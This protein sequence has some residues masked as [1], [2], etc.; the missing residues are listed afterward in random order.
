MK[1]VRLKGLTWRDPRGYGPLPA[2]ERSFA[3]LHR[4]YNLEFEW[5][6]HPLAEFES[7]PLV[8]VVEQYDLM[9]A[10]HPQIARACRGG[11]LAALGDLADEFVGPSL[12][13][14][15]WEG[16]LWA[17]PV[18]AACHVAAY[19]S[20]L[21][22]A[23]PQTWDDLERLRSAG[24]RIAVPLGGVH[25]LMALLSLLGSLLRSPSTELKEIS[26]GDLQEALERLRWLASLCP[27]ECLEIDPLQVLTGLAEGKW[28]YSPLVFGYAHYE[29]RGVRFG[30]SPASLA[31][32]SRGVLGGAGIAVSA[33]S[34]CPELAVAFAR[35]CCE[36]STQAE[37]WPTGGGQPAHRQAWDRLST[38][39]DFFRCTREAIEASI[40]RPRTE[41][42]VATQTQ[43]GESISH[44]LT[45]GG[46]PNARL[47]SNLEPLRYAT[48]A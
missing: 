37:L 34:H 24:A 18:D 29:N 1:Q 17:A 38:Q 22:A 6:V 8:E 5:D 45:T 26:S 19:R 20:N 42:F 46:P 39:S 10:D 3:L 9:V 44:W 15:R 25:A 2:V 14:Y 30:R 40:L 32:S 48:A 35:F 13:S 27:N 7:R 36:A 21:E 4:E 16:Q 28:D 23:C 43:V 41:L 47:A 31:D 11:Y 12:A 33:R